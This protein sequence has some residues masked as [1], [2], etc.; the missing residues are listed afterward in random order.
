MRYLVRSTP[1][2]LKLQS[3]QQIGHVRQNGSAFP[4]HYL[5]TIALPNSE[6]NSRVA[7]VAG[8]RVGNAIKRN[9]AKRLIRETV[10]ANA[11]KIPQGIDIMIIARHTMEDVTLQQVSS[12][13]DKTL[14]RLNKA[15]Q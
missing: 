3:S 2:I 6:G 1:P 7:V 14:R 4:N 13:F 10:R 11:A 8:K 12:A 9:R 5:V 15:F